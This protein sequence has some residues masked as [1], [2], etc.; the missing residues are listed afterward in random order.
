MHLVK[1]KK[2]DSLEIAALHR[3]AFKG[4]FLTDLGINVL[5]VFYSSLIQD[6][7]TII[8]GVKSDDVLVGFFLVSKTPKNL[9]TRI[10]K[11]NFFNFFIPLSISLIKNL[12]LLRRLIVSMVSS[13]SVEVPSTYAASLLSICVEPSFSGKGIGK[14]LLSK[15][16]SELFINNLSG[17]YLTTDTDNNDATNYFYLN[18]GFFLHQIFLQGKRRMNVYLKN[19]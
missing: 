7:A 1:L 18:N 10:F 17:Y 4:F 11:I 16:E 12:S 8:W 6:K 5:R 2:E 13:K 3:A 9:Y 19:I 14:M 15:L